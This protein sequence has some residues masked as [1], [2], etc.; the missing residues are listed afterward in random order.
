MPAHV[1]KMIS[2]LAAGKYTKVYAYD[3]EFTTPP[4]GDGAPK[5]TLTDPQSLFMRCRSVALPGQNIET[6]PDAIRM[7][8]QRP[9]AFNVNFGPIVAVFLTDEKLSERQFFDDW[10]RS[11][12]EP[13]T[14]AMHY[15]KSYTTD[16]I[17]R[18]H[19]MVGNNTYG[20][21]LYEAWPKTFDQQGLDTLDGSLLTL[22]VTFEYRF[23]RPLQ[24]FELTVPKTTTA[25]SDIPI[26][27]G[28]LNTT[29]KSTRVPD[30]R[31]PGSRNKR[32]SWRGSDIPEGEDAVE[33]TGDVFDGT[34]IPDGEDMR[35]ME[36]HFDSTPIPL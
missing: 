2:A 3:I 19:D 10:H 9:H 21:K 5:V 24:D 35:D 16:M 20:V 15:Y 11:I 1:T 36:S 22:S 8:P 34:L 33:A 30:H 17:I 18:Q 32:R 7:G 13:G 12:Y 29:F 26:G 4:G 14:F 27:E 31:E 25:H 28:P 23:W 6:G